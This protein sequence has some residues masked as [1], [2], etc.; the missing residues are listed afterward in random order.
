MTDGH[1]VRKFCLSLDQIGQVKLVPDVGLSDLFHWFNSV[2]LY[3]LRF[4]FEESLLS[5]P[6]FCIERRQ[7]ALL[8][9]NHGLEAD[10]KTC[11]VRAQAALP[12][13]ARARRRPQE[14]ATLVSLT[15]S[16]FFISY[17][18]RDLLHRY[19]CFGVINNSFDTF[20]YCLRSHFLVKKQNQNFK[21]EHV[22]L[23]FL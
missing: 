11:D 6:F 12:C 15:G 1:D 8:S 2:R 9:S 4:G 21:S 22:L 13:F 17:V 7:P 10:A 3:D 23:Q 14:R 5:L 19:V 18:T 16:T 20:D